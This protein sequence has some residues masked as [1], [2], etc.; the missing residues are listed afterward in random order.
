LQA[1]AV[2][3]D[4]TTLTIGAWRIAEVCED[5]K[6]VA[7]RIGPN[8]STRNAGGAAGDVVDTLSP[9]FNQ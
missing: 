2:R 3:I 9:S 1:T 6:S 8:V 5:T 7:V 4:V